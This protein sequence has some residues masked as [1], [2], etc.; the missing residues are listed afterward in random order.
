MY[1]SLLG[2]IIVYLVGIPVSYLTSCDED[3]AS[4]DERLLT[5]CMRNM[6]RRKKAQL[7]ENKVTSTELSQLFQERTIQDHLEK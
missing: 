5:P 2:T 7:T 3:L 1:Y 6:L 4:L